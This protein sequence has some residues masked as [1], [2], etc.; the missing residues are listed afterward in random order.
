MPNIGI[1]LYTL[2]EMMQEAYLPTLQKVADLG[3]EGVEFAGYGGMTPRELR[4]AV[5]HLGLTPVSSHVPLADLE[6]S[7]ERVV[8]QSAE[9]GLQH[10]FCP[11]L[12]EERRQTKA[13]YQRLAEWLQKSG[14]LFAE[15]NIGFGYHNHAF[16]FMSFD[17]IFALDYLYEQT[18]A[19]FVEA[20]LDLYW[21]AYANQSPSAYIERYAGR[22]PILHMKDM[23]PDEERFFAPVGHGCLDWSSIFTAANAS[24]V[25]W[26][27]VEQD[28]CRGNPLE[29]IQSSFEFLASHRP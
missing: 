20:E 28:V 14:E 2:R 12:P 26:Y 6:D 10:V 11:Y 21:I 19:K 13:D 25:E 5:D 29:S 7:L 27:I 9:L 3:F 17:G 16:E 22:C 8:E 23:T 15:A 4:H 24:G 18:D 1:Q